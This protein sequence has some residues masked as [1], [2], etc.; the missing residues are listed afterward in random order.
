MRWSVVWGTLRCS[1]RSAAGDEAVVGS[2][3]NGLFD[4]SADECKRDGAPA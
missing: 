4:T 3:G 2:S 1:S